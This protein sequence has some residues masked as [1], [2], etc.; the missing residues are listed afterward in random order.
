MEEL[1]YE[2]E[3]LELELDDFDESEF[4]ERRLN[5]LES[6][7]DKQNWVLMYSNDN[8]KY[9]EVPNSNYRKKEIF[10]NSGK[11]IGV[12]TWKEHISK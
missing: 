3:D 4:D 5:E 1:N 8:E 2:M 11:M 6:E 10:N 9:Y 12:S 7:Y